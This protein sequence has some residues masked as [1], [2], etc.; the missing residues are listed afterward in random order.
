MF[1][2]VVSF[3]SFSGSILTAGTF[4][5]AIAAATAALADAMMVSDVCPQRS[6]D[7]VSTHIL[8]VFEC[9]QSSTNAHDGSG[10]CGSDGR[11]EV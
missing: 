9:P 5:A 11:I 3:L 10:G 1:A 4:L 2:A 8:E 6:Q 7:D